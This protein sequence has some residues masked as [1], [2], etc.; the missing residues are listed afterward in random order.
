MYSYKRKIF[1]IQRSLQAL[2]LS[3]LIAK[4]CLAAAA[5]AR[6]SRP[7]IL[8][9]PTVAIAT[10]VIAILERASP[11]PVPD[12]VGSGRPGGREVLAVP[13][14]AP[15]R[16]P[17][18]NARARG[19]TGPKTPGLPRVRCR[20]VA[21][22]LTLRERSRSRR[23][24]WIVRWTYKDRYDLDFNGPFRTLRP[25]EGCRWTVRQVLPASAAADPLG[26]F[27]RD[28]AAAGGKPTLLTRV[29]CRCVVMVSYATTRSDRSPDIQQLS[30]Y[31]LE[32][33]LLEIA[34]V[35]EVPSDSRTPI[36]R[37]RS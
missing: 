12:C 24:D 25:S 27:S 6:P 5:D 34:S 36:G 26:K 32:R 1:T 8:F 16:T 19:A 17:S 9:P 7:R 23:R 15:R 37:K 10:V 31:P 30:R 35:G 18:V 11:I 14:A 22:S 4:A 3:I 13:R 20:L 28:W 21:M 33:S 2:G 29:W